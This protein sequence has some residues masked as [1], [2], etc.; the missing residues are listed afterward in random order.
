VAFHTSA[1]TLRPVVLL[2]IGSYTS[3][4]PFDGSLHFALP[5]TES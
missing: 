2:Y 5:L 1:V 4:N 3:L